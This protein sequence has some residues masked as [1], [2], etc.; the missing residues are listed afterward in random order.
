M[1]KYT[2][3]WKRAKFLD[4]GIHP[5]LDRRIPPLLHLLHPHALTNQ[6][7]STWICIVPP[8]KGTIIFA[9][10]S[11]VHQETLEAAYLTA[12]L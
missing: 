8:G 11:K 3:I 6:K 10:I 4:F 7:P 5:L 9:V 2:F 12:I 1:H